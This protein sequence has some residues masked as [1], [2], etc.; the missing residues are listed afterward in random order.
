M[1]KNSGYLFGIVLLET[2]RGVISTPLHSVWETQ[3]SEERFCSMNSDSDCRVTGF[4]QC[5]GTDELGARVLTSG[6]YN[7][8]PGLMRVRNLHYY[9]S[10]SR[11]YSR[12]YWVRSQLI[13]LSN[14][15]SWVMDLSK[16]F[17]DKLLS[18]YD[19]RIESLFSWTFPF[20]VPYRL[21]SMSF[22][23][24]KVHIEF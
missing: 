18:I 19:I 4:V 20:W 6:S 16:G 2:V 14:L 15:L 5:I 8:P 9:G 13:K 21:P 12:T 23:N 3:N 24:Q 7:H 1:C 11:T 10:S 22:P 17:L